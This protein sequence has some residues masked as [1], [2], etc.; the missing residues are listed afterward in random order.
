[1]AKGVALDG[2][3]S[4]RA[5]IPDHPWPPD[6]I[7]LDNLIDRVALLSEEVRRRGDVARWSPTCPPRLPRRV[8]RER[9]RADFF[10]GIVH[11]NLIPG[12]GVTI[13]LFGQSEGND[14]LGESGV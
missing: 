11:A 6:D 7:V 12:P 13:H 5:A 10:L 8:G 4:M 2:Y 9:R 1:V 3:V 14:R